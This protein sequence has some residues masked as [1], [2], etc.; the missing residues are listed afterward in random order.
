VLSVG[1]NPISLDWTGSDALLSLD[2]AWGSIPTIRLNE[3]LGGELTV[4]NFAGVLLNFERLQGPFQTRDYDLVLQGART[5]SVATAAGDDSILV[6]V[7]SDGGTVAQNRLTINT[8][9]G[10]DLVEI[11]ASATDFVGGAY[12]P[13][14]TRSIVNLGQ[15][16]DTF[17]GGNGSDIVTGGAG[18]D[19]LDGRGGYDIA[20]FAGNR[21]DYV[22][23]VL[24]A[25]SGLSTVAGLDGT[26][27]V[28]RFEQ[29]RFDDMALKLQGG[30]WV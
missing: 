6:E 15:G 12:D 17:L 13:A 2:N 18:N 3:F 26:D 22:V 7:D 10:N 21:A 9:A 16:D 11:R 27:T 14:I 8:N 1:P 29:L 5:A 20:I 4:R 23:V 25:A 28:V 19:T 30:I 24:D